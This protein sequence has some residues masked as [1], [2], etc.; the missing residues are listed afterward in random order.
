MTDRDTVL[1]AVL[2]NPADDTVRLV[3]GDILQESD[4]PADRARGRF[5]CAGV[6]ASRFRDHDPIEDPAYYAAQRELA[7]VADTG[8]PAL[9]LSALGPGPQPLTVADW[10]WDCAH[11]RLTVRVGQAAGVFARG[12]LAE[13]KVTL[14][15]WYAVGSV[16]L[17]AWPLERA[18]VT[19]V[20]G[21]SFGV[22]RAPAGWVLTARL[23]LP[24]RRV[25]LGWGPV[26]AAVSPA[27][28]LREGPGDWR[29]EEPFPDRPALVAGLSRVSA[30]LAADLRDCAGDRW[31]PPP[32]KGR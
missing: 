5:L 7:A 13:L 2:D 19:D 1:A 12:M 18:T 31:P 28:A 25:P 23:R 16:A 27:P 11:D 6:A 8:L 17:A 32:R 20:P 10:G 24:A 14:A 22:A 9:W 29:V 26:P 4:D 30:E 21:L 15:E 3:L